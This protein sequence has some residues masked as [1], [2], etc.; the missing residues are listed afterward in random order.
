MLASRWRAPAWEGKDYTLFATASSAMTGNLVLSYLKNGKYTDGLP[1]E[2]Q[3][4]GKIINGDAVGRAN[5]DEFVIV[6]SHGIAISD[7]VVGEMVLA[8]AE[9]RGVGVMLP[10][11]EEMD[12]LR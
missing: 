4:L 6:S 5:D 7:V 2:H 9:E 3:I 1:E 8:K 10:L 11:M 12:I